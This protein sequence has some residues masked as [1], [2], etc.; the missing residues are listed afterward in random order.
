VSG[1]SIEV[2]QGKI[3]DEIMRCESCLILR[4]DLESLQRVFHS[5][6][7]IKRKPVVIT[8]FEDLGTAPVIDEN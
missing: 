2:L 5:V 7:I 8:L 3:G 6:K 4:H 1:L